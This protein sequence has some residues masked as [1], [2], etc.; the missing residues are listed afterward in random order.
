VLKGTLTIRNAA[1]I[2]DELLALLPRFDAFHIQVCQVV[3]LDLSFV[4]LLLALRK[5]ALIGEKKMTIEMDTSAGLQLLLK[6]SGL[7]DLIAFKQI[8]L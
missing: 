4:Q 2:R 5:T 7:Y 8:M 6:R 1:V 3:E